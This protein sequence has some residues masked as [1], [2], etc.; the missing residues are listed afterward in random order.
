M[1]VA[2]G[3]RVGFVSLARSTFDV[4]L[5]GQVTTQLHGALTSAGLQLCGPGEP[6]RDPEALQAAVVALA[7]AVR[8]GVGSGEL[9]AVGVGGVWNVTSKCGGR[10]VGWR[11]WKTRL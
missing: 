2:N 1:T 5:A 4:A 11:L 3:L 8:D 10:S 7:V 6:L 9:V